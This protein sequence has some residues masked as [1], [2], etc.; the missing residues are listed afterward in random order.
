MCAQSIDV[1]FSVL[2]APLSVAVDPGLVQVNLCTESLRVVDVKI[3]LVSIGQHSA[4]I[5][6]TMAVQAK[7]L[8]MQAVR[9]LS[10]G[11]MST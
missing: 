11:T 10:P 5:Y 6:T 8:A 2:T 9:R 7:Y 3:Q 4:L 1:I